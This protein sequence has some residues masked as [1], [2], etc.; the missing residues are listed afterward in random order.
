MTTILI[1][2]LMSSSCGNRSA[3]R[4]NSKNSDDTLFSISSARQDSL[5]NEGIAEQR[6][7][8]PIDSITYMPVSNFFEGIFRENECLKYKDAVLK[9]LKSYTDKMKDIGNYDVYYVQLRYQASADS[10][11]EYICRELLSHTGFMILYEADIKLANVILVEYN[12]LLDA[13]TYTMS[14][15]VNEDNQISL[16]ENA[17]VGNEDEQGN[18]LAE[19]KIK[20]K[21]LIDVSKEGEIRI[22]EQ[23]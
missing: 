9:S 14:F 1:G 7:L 3:D 20:S 16:I 23:K 11:S 18:Q 4:I 15:S 17:L 12:F 6:A 21:V 22:S 2:W 10:I 13:E 8:P 19:D 5:E